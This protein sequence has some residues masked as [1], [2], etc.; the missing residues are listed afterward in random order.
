MTGVHD[1]SLLPSNSFNKSM[2]VIKIIIMVVEIYTNDYDN[3]EGLIDME[4]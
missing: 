2:V 4:E 1:T 3:Y